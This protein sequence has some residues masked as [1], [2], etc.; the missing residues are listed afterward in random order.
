MSVLT[1]SGQSVEPGVPH[2]VGRLADDVEG[3]RAVTPLMRNRRPGLNTL[4]SG[5]HDDC[6]HVREIFLNTRRILTS[7]AT[8]PP[9][10]SVR[11]SRHRWRGATRC[12]HGR[13]RTASPSARRWGP[14]TSR[15]RAC[16][17]GSGPDM[18]SRAKQ[19][20]ASRESSF[21]PE[22]AMNRPMRLKI[23]MR[24]T[25][26]RHEEPTRELRRSDHT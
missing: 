25:T 6:R 26:R 4:I 8:R 10:W 14:R 16:S 21:V 19:S 5:P 7:T 13:L 2:A 12:R 15:S 22:A 3:R 11:N 9:D 18:R 1:I 23:G 20:G 17:V 24:G